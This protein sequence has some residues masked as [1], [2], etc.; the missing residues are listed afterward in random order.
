M[1][2]LAFDN[3]MRALEINPDLEAARLLL[4]SVTN[5]LTLEEALEPL[6]PKMTGFRPNMQPEGK[7]YRSLDFHEVVLLDAAGKFGAALAE[8]DR[9][10]ENAARPSKAQV[11]NAYLIN[12]YRQIIELKKF[13]QETGNVR[14]FPQLSNFSLSNG[15]YHEI[16]EIIATGS[17]SRITLST[18]PTE[19]GVQG[20]Y[21]RITD[22]YSRSQQNDQLIA[23]VATPETE[24][25]VL[26]KLANKPKRPDRERLAVENRS[27]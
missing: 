6:R 22:P 2:K 18:D 5:G 23:A 9:L 16:E 27:E 19:T 24:M 7:T 15:G 21:T 20:F 4:K 13:A 26:E 1:K 3:Y 11:N 17:I 14:V 12:D 10:E 8:L 25:E